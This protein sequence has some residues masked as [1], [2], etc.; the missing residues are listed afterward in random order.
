MRYDE[1]GKREEE[2]EEAEMHSKREST[3]RGVVGIMAP[4]SKFE[5]SRAP[6][7]SRGPFSKPYLIFSYKVIMAPEKTFE[8]LRSPTYS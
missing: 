5:I 3:H 8:S 2:E 6:T 7:Y 1:T 4:E